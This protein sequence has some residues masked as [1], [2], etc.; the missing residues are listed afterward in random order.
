LLACNPYQNHDGEFYAGAVDPVK[1]PKAY[2]GQG[3]DAKKGGGSF[4]PVAATVDGNNVAYFSFAF[5]DSQAMANDP[6]ALI[7]DGSYVPA[8]GYIFDPGDTNPFPKPARCQPP[9]DYLFDQRTDFV[10]YDEQGNVFTMLPSDPTYV[11]VVAQ[12]PVTSA[13]EPCQEIK[14]E[15]TLV[16]RADVSLP[17]TPPPVMLDNTYPTG[18]PDDKFLAWAI[19]DPDADVYL[20]PDGVK[21]PNNG[22]DP[23]TF[24]GPQKWGWYNHY[25]LAYIDGGYIPT[26]S[27]TVPGMMGMPDSKVTEMV[28]QPI[29]FP[30][31]HPD[32]KGGV[33]MPGAGA[34]GDGY[35]ILTYA[36]S[37]T[38]YTPICEVFTFD[39]KD[40]MNP[41]TKVDDI[42]MTTAMPTGDFIYC[43]QTQ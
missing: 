19:I 28:S 42:D 17:L 23:V 41:E 18:T 22:V 26:K 36:R 6:K 9:K 7:V 30:S 31:A 16:G 11:P 38:K 37:S 40:P 34:L 14:S 35:D 25:L 4:T 1:F 39:P 27:V 32:G 13:G 10:R 8:I 21:G 33:T 20:T 15:K 12:V 3:G 5:P 2:L 24:L 29:Y 43:L